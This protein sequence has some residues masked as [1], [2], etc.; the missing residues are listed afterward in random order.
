MQ[1]RYAAKSFACILL[2]ARRMSQKAFL[3]VHLR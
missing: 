2:R 3:L 1:R